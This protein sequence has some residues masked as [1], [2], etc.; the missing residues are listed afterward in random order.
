MSA[1]DLNDP[2]LDHASRSPVTVRATETIGEALERIRGIGLPDRILYF[3]VVNERGGLAGVVPTRRLLMSPPDARIASV[4]IEDVVAIPST[5]TVREACDYF[6][7]HRFLAF[8][9]V[10]PG[11]R[12]LVGVV[13]AG[14]FTDRAEQMM[15]RREERDLFQLIGVHLERGVRHSPWSGFRTRFPWLLCNIGGGILCALLSGLYVGLLDQVILLALFIPVVLAL[16]ESVSMQSMTITIQAFHA[17]R[18]RRTPVA[19]ALLR[20]F[21]TASLLGAGSGAVVGLIAW[22]WKGD[23]GVAL[24]LASAIFLSMLVACLLG[25]ALPTAVNAFGRDPRIASGPIVLAAA[26]VCTLLF[27]F[28]LAGWI[29][30]PGGA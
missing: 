27:F 28:T 25:V 22:L 17:E 14:L 24:S 7:R 8:P 21:L 26:D 13:D 30:L 15:R 16:A 2:V 3:Y 10:D 12:T 18:G 1:I 23:G 19:A 9:L 4:M 5:A 6:L 11:K 20:E 29:L